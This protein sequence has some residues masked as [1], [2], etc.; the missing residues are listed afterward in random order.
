MQSRHAKLGEHILF[1][2]SSPIVPVAGCCMIT[3][4]DEGS[5]PGNTAHPNADVAIRSAGSDDQQLLV[6]FRR[7]FTMTTRTLI[8]LRVH[9]NSMWEPD[10]TD[11]EWLSRYFTLQLVTTDFEYEGSSCATWWTVHDEITGAEENLAQ[12][13]DYHVLIQLPAAALADEISWV[14]LLDEDADNHTWLSY[15][16]AHGTEVYGVQLKSNEND[17]PLKELIGGGNAGLADWSAYLALTSPPD[18]LS[19][20]MPFVPLNV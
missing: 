7:S 14:P 10:D 20:A 11:Y 9:L 3:D 17:P 8:Q 5:G 6:R 19:F 12:P 4:A 16:Y 2:E 15:L 13:K 1:G 18:G